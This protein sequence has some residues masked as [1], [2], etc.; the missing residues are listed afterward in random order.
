MLTAAA[1]PDAPVALIDVVNRSRQPDAQ[2]LAEQ[3]A[4]YVKALRNNQTIDIKFADLSKLNTAILNYSVEAANAALAEMVAAAGRQISAARAIL[5]ADITMMVVAIVVAVAGLLVVQRRISAA[6]LSLT[7][8]MRRLADRDYSVELVGLDRRDEVGEMSRTVAVFKESMMAGDRLAGEKASE[9]ERKERR[10]SAVESLIKAFEN[11]VT[12]SLQTL[13]SASNELNATAQSMSAIADQGRSK[14]SSVANVSEQA[15]GNV[16]MVAAATEELSASIAEI[17]RQVAE[18]TA[19]AG[20]AAMQAEKTNDEVRT[21][22]D[23]AQRIGDVVALISGI[24]E[25]T[26]LLALNATIEAAR[27]GEAGKGFA[28]VAAEVKTLANQTAKATEE[29]TAQV[30]GI[31][32]ATR[33][34]VDA[35]QA[36]SSTIQRVNQIASAIAAAVEEQGAATREIARNVQ[37]ASEGTTELS[38]HI[39]GVSQSTTET[40]SAAGEV[41][42]SAK[43]L[44]R[45]SSDLRRDVDQFVGQLRVA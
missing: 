18:S 23:A 16:Q 25:Q 2:A 33:S 10:Q 4:A 39:V 40:G 6:I 13:A 5:F 8:A 12:T 20:A 26:N 43:T 32:G 29:I 44:A 9:Q 1:R 42:D 3:Q 31:Q 28:V 35:I 38:R 22:S 36:I 30:T 21:L 11:T 45:L 24:A 37:Q 27:A 7:A 41:L 19:I 17:A 14:A 34:S 15:S